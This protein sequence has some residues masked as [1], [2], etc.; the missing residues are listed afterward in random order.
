MTTTWLL[1]ARALFR[2]DL[3]TDLRHRLFYLMLFAEAAVAFVS[4]AFLARVFGDAKP[5][6]YEPLPFL[7]VG[8]ALTNALTTSL[9]YLSQIV[10]SNQ[11]AGTMK[12]LLAMPI[13]PTRWMWLS[14]PYPTLRAALEFL[15]FLGVAIVL[16]LP[17]A[18]INVGATVV[19]FL[20][21]VAA[22]S[23]LA[24]VS[25]AFAVAFKHGDPLRWALGTATWLVSGVLYPTDVLP[26][27]LQYVARLLPTTHALIAM[28]ATVIGGA[29]LSDV[30][31]EVMALAGVSVVGI[32]LAMWMFA[33]AVEYA[34]REGTIGHS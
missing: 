19:V 16:G 30:S 2:R 34:R 1:Q 12:A 20:L 17:S 24:L 27:A 21:A 22:T 13:S 28:R 14:M 18:S 29:G 10:R 3:M 33:H 7:L 26:V 9:V 32:P 5:D 23:A 25:A 11:E 31:R 6:G 8:I 15:V 4:Y